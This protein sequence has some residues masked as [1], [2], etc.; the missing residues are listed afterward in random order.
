M[1][2]SQSP[3]N[4]QWTKHQS[5]NR[6]IIGILELDDCLVF[7]IWCLVIGSAGCATY[8]LAGHKTAHAAYGTYLRGLMLE[9]SAK[10]TD[11]LNAYN[12]ALAHDRRSAL[13]NVRIGATYLMLGQAD[14]ALQAFAKALEIEP[15]QP[16]ALRWVAMMYASQGKLDEAVTAYERLLAIQPD[17]QFVISTLADLY[18]L[19]GHLPQAIDLYH[20]LIADTGPSSQLYF[21]L[22]VLHG[23]LNQYDE[24][25]QELSHAFELSPDSVDIRVALGLTYELSE[26]YDKAAAHYEDAARLDP[27]NPRLYHHAARAHLNGKRF[28]LAAADYQTILDLT[29]RDLEA[30][31]G[32]VRVRLSQNRFEEAAQ[33]LGH[34]I[35]EMGPS[36]ELYVALGIVYRE[37]KQAAEAM[38]A[39]ER[40][41]ANKEDYAQAYFYLAAQLDQLGRKQ[42]AQANLN[43]TLQLDPNHSDAMNYL[44]YLDAEAGEHLDEAQSLI[45]HA[46]ELEPENGA[47]LDS[48]GWVYFKMGK[49]EEAIA[50]LEHAASVLATD[51][52]IFDHLGEAYCT[53]HA[54]EKARRNWERALTLDPS[55]TAIRM[56]L[57]RLPSRGATVPAR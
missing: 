18:V 50:Q 10:L 30:I 34:K 32:L 19:Q 57:D 44:G 43:R 39:F 7:V 13:L 40:A 14:Q 2:K 41:I 25:L 21:N 11:A 5:P 47:Y 42:E 15:N 26:Q 20:Q 38:R 54:F 35:Q 9:R 29:P 27:L 49:L 3:N 36:P 37:A 28:D 4:H 31:M 56:K 8:P 53:Q 48:L 1:T 46:L 16:D 55:Q 24:A 45:Q 12:L 52:V 17:D 6:L 33:F 22:G 51:P 23:R